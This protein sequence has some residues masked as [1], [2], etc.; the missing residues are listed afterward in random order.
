[1]PGTQAKIVSDRIVPFPLTKNAYIRQC[2]VRIKSLQELDLG[3]GSPPTHA[4]LTE[5]LVMQQLKLEGQQPVW[6]IW[7]TTKPASKKEVEELIKEGLKGE[8]RISLM[9]RLTA[10]DPTRG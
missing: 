6:K 8:D 9:D 1:M 7:G 3:D 5:Y 2:I 4:D 10:M